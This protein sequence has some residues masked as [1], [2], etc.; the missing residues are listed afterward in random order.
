MA[1]NSVG[2]NGAAPATQDA[3]F[4]NQMAEFE[5]VSQKVQAQAV[6]MRRITTELSSEKKVADERVQ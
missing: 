4:Q 2:G 6:A 1:V 5:R 3:G